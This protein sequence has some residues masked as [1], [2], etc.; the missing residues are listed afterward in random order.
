MSEQAYLFIDAGYL[1]KVL[2]DIST[3]IGRPFD[4]DLAEIIKMYEKTFY[5][6]CP[7]SQRK[8]ESNH[9]FEL[10][11]TDHETD[12]E[13]ISFL[14]GCH[15]YEGTISGKGGRARQKGVDVKLA[16]DMLMHAM[17]RNAHQFTLLSGDRDFEP[18]AKAIVN[19]G[20]K[21]HVWAAQKSASKELLAAADVRS[22]M[23][24]TQLAS[25]YTPV[26]GREHRLQY[27]YRGNDKH[28]A[29]IYGDD[30][31]WSSCAGREDVVTHVVHTRYSGTEM[32]YAIIVTE[33][34]KQIAS[35][36]HRDY[37]YLY[38]IVTYDTD[39]TPPKIDDLPIKR[40]G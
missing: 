18:L 30:L 13:R 9:D 16:V 36:H 15:V 32:I 20:R 1:R 22:I 39:N 5:Y 29:D 23:T 7:P 14:D 10:R 11:A 27:R 17:A 26:S 3:H 2:E 21:M 33:G 8:D 4:I 19:S 25:T 28:P 38:G 31:I 40:E 6:D 35:W 34:N 37:E 24:A 12:I